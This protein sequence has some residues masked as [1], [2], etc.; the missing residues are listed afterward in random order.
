MTNL[1]SIQ[2]FYKYVIAFIGIVAFFINFSFTSKKVSEKY[3]MDSYEYFYFLNRLGTSYEECL[4]NPDKIHD[5]WVTDFRYHNKSI[6]YIPNQNDG[7]D[8]LAVLLE[9]KN[10]I[11]VFVKIEKAMNDG[12]KN[13][14]N[15]E[16]L[17]HEIPDDVINGLFEFNYVESIDAGNSWGAFYRA[18]KFK[19]YSLNKISFDFENLDSEQSIEVITSSYAALYSRRHDTRVYLTEKGKNK[20][21]KKLN[22]SIGFLLD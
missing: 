9:F 15:S 19:H 12:F 18:L 2:P 22:K 17:G 3:R 4:K 8:D 7:I 21:L 6:K 1:K 5:V 20:R 11:C 14:Q 16:A 13:Y 10:G